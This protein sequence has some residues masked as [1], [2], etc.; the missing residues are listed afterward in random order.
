M[1]PSIV[2]SDNS[3]ESKRYFISLLKDFDI[4]SVCT[5]SENPQAN[6]PIE[7][8][9]QVIHNMIVTKDI[10]KRSF[11]YINTWG[12]ILLSVTWDII[13]SHHSTFD[14]LPEQLVFCRDMILN[15]TSAIYWYVIHTR[16]KQADL[17]NL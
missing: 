11:D 16:K 3:S 17:D 15:L 14:S 8:V 12:E 9:H 1:R 10:K 2:V 13:A 5:T 6:I 4:K 7:W